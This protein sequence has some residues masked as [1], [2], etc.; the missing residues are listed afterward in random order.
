MSEYEETKTEQEAKENEQES[1]PDSH[2]SDDSS[3]S[4][5][6]GLVP[7]P[8]AAS[9]LSDRLSSELAELLTYYVDDKYT[10]D[11]EVE[12]DPFIGVKEDASEIFQQAEKIKESHN[13]D[14]TISITDL[15]LFKKGN[16]L[17]AEVDESRAMGQISLPSLGAAPLVR[18]V[19]EA[20]LQLVSELHHGTSEED[21]DKEQERIKEIGH[22]SG[23]N[24]N[25]IGSRELVK[26][27]V[28]KRLAPI[29]RMSSND[30]ENDK[31]I[32]YVAR[33]KLNGYMR[34]ATGMVRANH[35]W[36]IITTF[37]SVVALAFTTGAYA[38]IFPT[39]WQLGDAYTWYRSLALMLVALSAM[40]A[41]LIIS[42]GL[43]EPKPK[44]YKKMH[45][46]RLH[47]A[48][49][50]LTIS[51]GVICYYIVLLLCFFIA[52]FLFIPPAMLE[53]DSG[54][55]RDV[56]PMYYL[57]LAWLVSS[58]ATCI[59][60]LGAGLEDEETVLNGTYGYRQRIRKEQVKKQEEKKE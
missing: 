5:T 54:I 52:V 57:S 24:I 43:W 20:V 16:F 21:R 44:D 59:G 49:T 47:N 42:H 56:G 37:K 46:T 27:G 33:P 40:T 36:K 7:A 29:Y 17:V 34:V 48:S 11:V 58:L 51:V 15:P 9:D 45:L 4:L 41:W 19:R 26:R 30:K 53:S 22:R 50:L 39:L 31:E 55:G 2:S 35:P 10:W 25:K 60:A 32:M 12:V 28:F 8:E 38:L 14:Y 3:P 6:L 1:M 18:R 23:T 13:W